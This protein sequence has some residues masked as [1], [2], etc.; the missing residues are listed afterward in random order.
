MHDQN[1]I[2]AGNNA[3]VKAQAER[4]L[5]THPAVVIQYDGLHAMDAVGFSDRDAAEKAA[6]DYSNSEYGRTASLV[7]KTSARRFERSIH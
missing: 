7:T 4:L 5:A 2:E 3:V 1:Q 6:Q